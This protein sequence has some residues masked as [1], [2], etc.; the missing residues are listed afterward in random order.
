MSNA[1]KKIEMY[2]YVAFAKR[3]EQIIKN[4]QCCD[5]EDML[6]EMYCKDCVSCR[7]KKLGI[8]LPSPVF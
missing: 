5:Q 8:G 6:I 1:G 4:F 2:R 3:K 7:S